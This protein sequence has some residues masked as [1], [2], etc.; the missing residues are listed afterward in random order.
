MFDIS[1]LL[2]VSRL[3]DWT[4]LQFS[5]SIQ[6]NLFNLKILRF[7]DNPGHLSYGNF[8]WIITPSSMRPTLFKY[9]LHSTINTCC[10]N[11][12]SS[13]TLSNLTPKLSCSS[14][15]APP[16][17]PPSPLGRTAYHVQ[18]CSLACWTNGLW[19]PNCNMARLQLLT[20]T[21]PWTASEITDFLSITL[22]GLH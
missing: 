4:I 12:C 11:R 3:V 22:I 20:V 17:D 15:R 21:E 14:P 6:F 19:R 5:S 7:I 18:P 10:I 1:T 13:S 16:T 9:N 2:S 8:K